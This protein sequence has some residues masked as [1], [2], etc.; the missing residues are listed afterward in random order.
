MMM[1]HEAHSWSFT[2]TNLFQ[3]VLP[4]PAVS[5][6]TDVGFD[7]I[8]FTYQILLKMLD[9]VLLRLML[10]KGTTYYFWGISLKKVEWYR[11]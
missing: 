6:S 2:K 1:V 3:V 7:C 8:V 5:L 11:F 9:R 10:N 4:Y